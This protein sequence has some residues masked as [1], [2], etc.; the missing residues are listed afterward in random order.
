MSY[1]WSTA[2][3]VLNLV[4]GRTKKIQR[5]TEVVTVNFMSRASG[6]D[7]HKASGSKKCGQLCARCES[8]AGPSYSTSTS[9]QKAPASE[10]GQSSSMN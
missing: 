7:E 10:N 4:S 8:E 2:I 1:Y 5:L 9:F 3:I 6:Q